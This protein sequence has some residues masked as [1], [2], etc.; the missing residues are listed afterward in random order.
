ML[1]ISKCC[2]DPSD[3]IAGK[4][5]P[6]RRCSE[7]RCC[8]QYEN[9]WALACQRWGPLRHQQSTVAPPPT[10]SRQNTLQQSTLITLKINKTGPCP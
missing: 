5:A 6:T 2:G 3:A 9:L 8:D 4:P 10:P 1:L 7:R